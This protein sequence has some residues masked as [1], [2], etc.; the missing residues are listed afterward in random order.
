MWTEVL[1]DSQADA[2]R[3]TSPHE[4]PFKTLLL[5]LVLA[6]GGLLLDLWTS[7]SVHIDFIDLSPASVCLVTSVLWLF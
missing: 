5:T 2:A 7:V 1:T 4:L 3:P 6:W